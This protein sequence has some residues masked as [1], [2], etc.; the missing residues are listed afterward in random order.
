M[1]WCLRAFICFGTSGERSY[2]IAARFARSPKPAVMVPEYFN[3]SVAT[4]HVPQYV[5]ALIAPRHYCCPL[6]RYQV[7]QCF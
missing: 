5:T 7:V 1:A 2:G 3:G 6:T 4:V